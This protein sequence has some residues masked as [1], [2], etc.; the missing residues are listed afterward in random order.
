MTATLTY[1][2][3]NRHCIGAGE[4]FSASYAAKLGFQCPSCHQS[5]VASD[6]PVPKAVAWPSGLDPADLPTYLAHPWAALHGEGDPRVKLHW[7]IDTAEVAVRWTVAVALA[8]VLE[9][10]GGTLSPAVVARLREHIERPTLGQWLNI[11]RTL[12]AERPRPP[13]L[14]SERLF[15]LYE[16]AVA[17]QFRGER[18]GGTEDNSLLVVRNRLVHGGGLSSA[19]AHALTQA[20]HERLARLLRAVVA[21]TPAVEVIAVAAGTGRYLRGLLPEPVPLPDAL[22]GKP[23]G[24]WLVGPGGVLPLL[25]LLDYGP[26]QRVDI[27]GRLAKLAGDAAAQ[28]YLRAD[29][30]RLAYTPLGRDEAQSETLDIAAFRPLFRLDEPREERSVP[31]TEG[32][33]WDDFLREARVLA[34]EL[35]G[36]NAERERLKRWL[37][38][39][40]TR[41]EKV[42]A[43]G[44]L[45]GA[46]G[47]GKS[48]LVAR[49]AAD[50]A[51]APE[52][53]QGVFYHCFR[54]GDAR[55]NRRAFLRL[56]QAALARW[57]PLA[58]LTAP[59]AEE[60]NEGEVL[61]DDVKARLQSVSALTADGP[62]AP[63]FLV[64]LDGLDEVLAQDPTLPALI[65]QLALP[66]SVW[67]LAGRPEQGLA[68]GFAG[69]ETLFPGDGLPPM[70]EEDIRALLLE[71]LASARAALLARD[72][73]VGETVRNAFV[74]R[75]VQRSH[76][77]PLYVYLL[78]EDLRAGQFTVHDEDRLPEG[79]N[80]Y[81]DA[82]TERMGLSTVKADLTLLV[83][84]LAR[85]EEPLDTEALALLMDKGNPRRLDRLRLRMQTALRAGRTLLRLAL[86]R[87]GTEGYTLYHESY[88]DYIGGRR[89]KPGGGWVQAPTPALSDKVED[90]EEHFG[91]AADGWRHLPAG[92]LRNHL[93]RWGTQYALAWQEDGVPAVL[94]RLTD[95]AYLQARTAALPATEVTRLVSEYAQMLQRLPPQE[96]PRFRLWEAFFREHAHLLRRGNDQWPTHKILLQLA[97]E[98]ADDS[99][100]T[101]AA[102]AWL[103]SCQ[104]TPKTDPLTTPKIDP[105]ICLVIGLE[106]P[107]RA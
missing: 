52:Q 38:G 75:V 60:A 30:H 59:P 86:T 65:R 53:R 58:A 91:A 88:R 69:A 42:A 32:F 24:P 100:V 74:E 82:L 37:K 68:E 107:K 55:N 12:S 19:G 101:L 2:C 62:G 4:P 9:A 85:A 87:D 89:S 93:F 26:V 1:T 54:G 51:N 36:R 15:D 57:S 83:C 78:I 90:A 92:N 21:A 72:E 16:D 6:G 29:R 95:F 27:D 35:I 43:I 73:D 64:L 97:M 50:A 7:L 20:H 49:L 102:E 71:G 46:P 25:P 81:Y 3:R 105:Q 48:L 66:G 34:E 40:D 13:L 14:A 31:A 18:E 77:L 67:V 104:A 63:R 84:L 99:P 98:H 79:L 106:R 94:Q 33:R 10:S 70:A 5:L 96:Q 28:V 80:R 39:R 76:G 8:E 47:I 22:V 41:Q 56:L 45:H 17:P 44:W 103:D 23:D 61:V 11:L